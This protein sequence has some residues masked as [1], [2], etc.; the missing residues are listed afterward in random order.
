MIDVK[1]I[2]S[3]RRATRAK[4]HSVFDQEMLD[5]EVAN[6]SLLVRSKQGRGQQGDMAQ[7]SDY[8]QQIVLVVTQVLHIILNASSRTPNHKDMYS[9]LTTEIHVHG[10][11]LT[12]LAKA[13]HA[14]AKKQTSQ[15]LHSR[16]VTD[17][18][19]LHESRTARAQPSKQVSLQVTTWSASAILSLIFRQF[20]LRLWT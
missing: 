9:A 5:K 1:P 8:C 2:Y 6:D 18:C 12:A 20:E 13:P 11:L 16:R 19:K 7:A 15:D 10:A 3:S 14:L 4:T 17:K